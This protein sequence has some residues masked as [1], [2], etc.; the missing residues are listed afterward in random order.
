MNIRSF[1]SVCQDIVPDKDACIKFHGLMK[2][3]LTNLAIVQRSLGSLNPQRKINDAFLFRSPNLLIFHSFLLP[4]LV[5][6]PH[7]HGTWAVIG[8]YHGQEDNIYYKRGNGTLIETGKQSLQPG[9]VVRLNPETIHAVS[10]PLSQPSRALHIY[11]T[12]LFSTDRSMWNPWTLEESPFE[13]NQFLMY[14]Q[15]MT[16]QGSTSHINPGA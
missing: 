11:G 13:I 8:L 2:T 5:S 12:D 3:T 15:T 9:D 4:N 1:I 14:S 7:T 6:P 10:N 16:Q